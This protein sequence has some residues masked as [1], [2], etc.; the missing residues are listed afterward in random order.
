MEGEMKERDLLLF[1]PASRASGSRLKSW[2]ALRCWRNCWPRP[3]DECIPFTGTRRSI[4]AWSIPPSRTPGSPRRSSSK[5]APCTCDNRQ[6]TVCCFREL[7][8]DTSVHARFPGEL[9]LVRRQLSLG[10][11]SEDRNSDDEED[12]ETNRHV[13]GEHI[14]RVGLGSLRPHAHQL[15]VIILQQRL[16]KTS[17]DEK[18]KGGKG[19]EAVPLCP[20]LSCRGIA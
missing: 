20:S 4:S 17:E 11:A 12:V 14:E 3:P 19:G 7:K 8:G 13:T 1:N 6:G 2:A 5:Q 16:C 10:D 15:V 9:S 18:G